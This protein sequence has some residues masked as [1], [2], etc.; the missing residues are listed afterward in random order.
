MWKAQ[1]LTSEDGKTTIA[2]EVSS[3]ESTQEETDTRV[4]LYIDYAQN[5][6]Y[7][8]V[9][10]KSPDSDIFLIL[11]HYAD[12]LKNITILFDTGSGNKKRLINISEMAKSLTPMFCSALLSLHVFT[13]CDTTSAFK[14]IGK[15]KP[16]KVLEKILSTRKYSLN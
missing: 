2:P 6:G 1:L 8:Y 10:V 16:L 15:L 7:R 3:W 4:I 11:L 13:G 9:R 12:I 14:G 5:N